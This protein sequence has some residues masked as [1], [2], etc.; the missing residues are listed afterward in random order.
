MKERRQPEGLWRALRSLKVLMESE[1]SGRDT[2]ESLGPSKRTG[3][4]T[5]REPAV[6][7]ESLEGGRRASADRRH[8]EGAPG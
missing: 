8:L 6:R 2:M 5:G 3:K 1:G 7:G 4:R